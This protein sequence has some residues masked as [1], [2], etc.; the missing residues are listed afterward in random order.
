[1]SWK[2]SVKKNFVAKEP[3]FIEG[4]PGIGNVGKVVVDYLIE[5]LNAKKIG[6]LFSYDLPNSVF[7]NSKNLVQLPSIDLFH[8]VIKNK[9]FLFL[10]G[11]AQPSTERASYELSETIISFLDG[12]AT[13]EIITLGGIG[14]EE[15]PD[16][17]KVFVTGN[18]KSLIK[19]LSVVGANKKIFGI[20]GPIV[21]VSGLL[22]GLTKIPAGALLVETFAHPMYIGLKEA[23]ELMKVIS[24]KYSFKIDYKDL[25]EEISLV[26]EELET[27]KTK[28]DK[29]KK[30]RYGKT[31]LNKDLH[32]IG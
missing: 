21:G 2:L 15:I 32:Y 4:L 5:K 8:V 22:L 31:R 14:L 19:E 27:S 23:K 24:K 13:K 11:D 9:D 10:T 6:S 26:E 29:N 3:V 28:N 7:V 17:P 30:V 1:M 20:V 16:K 12:L 18:N 25:D